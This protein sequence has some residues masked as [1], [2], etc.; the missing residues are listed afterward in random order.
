MT[1]GTEERINTGSISQVASCSHA[2]LFDELRGKQTK[3]RLCGLC[4]K[5]VVRSKKFELTQMQLF[6][7]DQE[8]TPIF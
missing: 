7:E 4:I 8:S 5:K 1:T 6:V 2:F 3:W